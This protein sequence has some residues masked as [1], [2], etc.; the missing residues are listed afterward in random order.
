MKCKIGR[1]PHFGAYI[2]IYISLISDVIE[3]FIKY[4]MH[5]FFSKMD[6]SFDNLND[7]VNYI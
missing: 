4:D 6:Y 1:V 7:V 5:L 2:G 3:A